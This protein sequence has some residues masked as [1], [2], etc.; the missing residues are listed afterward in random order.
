[1]DEQEKHGLTEAEMAGLRKWRRFLGLDPDKEVEIPEEVRKRSR[2]SFQ[3]FV[4]QQEERR[5]EKRAREAGRPETDP[6]S[7]SGG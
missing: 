3:E 2:A 7:K 4:R 5:R 6:T 1:M